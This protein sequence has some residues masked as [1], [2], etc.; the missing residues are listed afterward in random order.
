FFRPMVSLS[1]GANRWICDLEPRCYGLTNLVLAIACAAAIYALARS[2]AIPRGGALL[3]SAV[4]AFN[5][6]GIEMGV[7]WISGRTALVAVLLSTLAAAAFARQRMWLAAA[8]C[9]A[10]MLAKEEAILVPA[11]LV[12][13]GAVE[14]RLGER[15]DRRGVAWFA[16]VSIV[17]VAVYLTLRGR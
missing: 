16:V 6:H 15:V 8:L 13:W 11:V 2:L 12:A 9:L 5:W 4:W 7:L 17:C 10:A 14:S 3:A 1:F